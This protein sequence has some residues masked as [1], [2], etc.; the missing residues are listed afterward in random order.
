MVSVGVRSRLAKATDGQ[1]EEVILFCKSI[2]AQWE[3][4]KWDL[5][6][7]GRWKGLEV[8]EWSAAED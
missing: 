7:S 3:K 2:K 4:V 6:E 1:C 8:L 5:M